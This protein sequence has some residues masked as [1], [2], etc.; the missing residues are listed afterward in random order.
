MKNHKQITTAFFALVFGLVV[1]MSLA[2][3]YQTNTLQNKSEFKWPEG[4]KMGMSLTFDDARLSQP[5]KGIPLLD[6]YGVKATFYLSP[7]SMEKRLEGWRKAV[8]S[9]HEIGNHSLTH[10]CTGNFDWS[11]DNA[12]EDYTLQGMSMNLDSANKLI[13]KILGVQPVS[14]AFPCGQKTIGRGKSTKSYIPVVSAMF[15]TGRG[16]MDEAPNDPSYCDMDQL[17]GMELDGKSFDQVKK[18]IESA[19]SKGQW[20]ILAG[21]EMNEG[22]NQTSLLPTI[23]AICKYALDPSNG[24]WIDN[25]HKIAGYIKEKRGET[26]FAETPV[27]KNALLPINQRI[28]DL[29]SRMTL[30][31]KVGQ[32]N[33]PTAYSSDLGSGLGS[34]AGYLWDDPSKANRDKQLEGCRK[35]AEGTH[36]NLFGPGGGFFTLSDRLIYEG[37]KRQ[38][39]VMNELQ[40]IA[41]DKTRLGIPLFQIEEGTHGLM[42]PGGTVFPEGLA[43]GATWNK[44]LVKRIYTVAAREGKAIG[45]HGLC[46]LVIEPNRDP[47][48]GRNEEGF[49]EDPYL[50][51]QIAG[52]IV[53]AIQGNDISEPDKLVAFLCHYPGQSQPVGGFERGAMEISDR[54][55]REV[56]LPPFVA[57]IKKYGALGVM[58]TYPAI[59]GEAAHSSEKILTKVLREELGFKGIVVSEG[60]GLGTIVTERHAATQKEAGVLAI[61]AGVD[62]GISIEDAYMG[63]LIENVNEGKISIQDVDKAVSRILRLKFQMGLFENPYVDPER[64]VKVVHSDENKELALQ[65]A[66]ESIVLLKNEKNILPLKKDIKSIAVIGPNA[67]AAMNQLGDYFPHNIPQEVVTVLKG[68]KNKVPSKTKISYV[69][70]CDV[71]GNK[72]DEIQKAKIAAKNADIAIVVIGEDGGATNGE[73]HDMANLDL[74]GRQEELLKAV[75]ETGT[76]TIVVL[77]NGRPL[78]I[79][80]A[81]EHI[82][83]IVEAWMC[84]EQGGN[85]VADVLFGDYN[86]GGKLP[87]TIPRHSGQFPFYYNHSATKSGANYIDMPGTPLYEFGYGLSYTKFEYSNLQITPKETGVKGDVEITV[88]LKNIGGRKGDEVVQ[89]YINDIVSTTSKPVKELKGYERIKLEPGEKKTV[90]FRLLPEDLSLFDRNMNFVVEPGTFIFMVGSSSEDIR[91]KGEFQVKK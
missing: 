47:R 77:I 29:I 48:M 8:S 65:T 27:Y 46:T 88:D 89:L 80:W 64:A 85:A 6:Q 66:R 63:G 17:T 10:P 24:I 14:F 36:N 69:K 30:K 37:P 31:E 16:W 67:D 18:I 57:G 3:S 34:K 12:L 51:S 49:S 11:R 84:G 13:K 38:A 91:L 60:G 22:G 28:E 1:N 75:Y 78:S 52:N 55:F 62:V 7:G 25:V 59:D 43:I 72:V 87:I 35:W 74:T 83:A 58:A 70:G 40:K 42:C 82:P 54:K 26:S 5:D 79:R 23:E 73:G 9:G 86:P 76:P 61:K 71:I 90:K 44:D 81:A 68:I 32:M 2:Q 53:Q 56:F 39:E 4:K 21:H 45:L 15:E 50:C 33:I 20:L 41:L 19:K